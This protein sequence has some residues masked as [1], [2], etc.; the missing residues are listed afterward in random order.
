MLCVGS[1]KAYVLRRTKKESVDRTATERLA[2]PEPNASN[3]LLE[4]K[5]PSDPESSTFPPQQTSGSKA[6][7]YSVLGVK[8]SAS[9]SQ[10]KKAYHKKALRCH[11]DKHSGDPA[12]T[13]EFQIISNA[14]NVLKDEKKRKMYD[15]LGEEGVRMMEQGMQAVSPEMV[16]AMFMQTTPRQ[17]AVLAMIICAI[18]SFGWLFPVFVSLEVDEKVGWSWATAFTPLWIIDAFGI[19]CCMGC[20]QGLW[21]GAADDAGLTP[22]QRRQHTLGTIS[23]C[24]GFILL[25]LQQVGL[26]LRLDHHVDWDWT[27]V[28]LPWIALEIA[29][30]L[31]AVVGSKDKFVIFADVKVADRQGVRSTCNFYLFLLSQCISGGA[32][33]WFAILLAAKLDDDI[34]DATWWVAFAPF[35]I[36]FA[37]KAVSYVWRYRMVNA[38]EAQKLA[39]QRAGV[40]AGAAGQDDEYGM[41]DSKAA[42]KTA[43]GSDVLLFLTLLLTCFKA[44]G[45]SFSTMYIYIPFAIPI[46]CVC[47]GMCCF[48]TGGMPTEEDIARMEA[49]SRARQQGRGRQGARAEG[50]PAAARDVDIESGSGKVD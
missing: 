35:W 8:Q 50:T 42:I 33:L 44:N 5:M 18:V 3:P 1:G 39:D 7:L 38:R 12:K 48:V 37:L 47:C 22:E 27:T 29:W 19:C 9:A 11:P 20:L 13:R 16:A 31:M 34:E 36:S 14:Y 24:G 4:A 28:L 10:I 30:L 40:S 26:V 17:K 21:Q 32:R 45:S 23:F 15:Q 46:T 41:S 43:M 25:L 6:T 49:E 2:G